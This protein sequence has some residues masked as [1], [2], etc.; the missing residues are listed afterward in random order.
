MGLIAW[1]GVMTVSG[2]LTMP[3]ASAANKSPIQ[4]GLVTSLTSSSLTPYPQ[5]WTAMQAAAAYINSSGGING[6][7]L[8]VTKCDDQDEANP[9]QACA[10]AAVHSKDVAVVGGTE[11]FPAFFSTLASAKLLFTGGLGLIPQELTS[12]TV[13]DTTSTAAGWYYGMGALAVKLGLKK[14]A[15][16][17]C[18][19]PACEGTAQ[20]SAQALKIAGDKIAPSFST[21]QL[22]QALTPAF[23]QQIM[24][25]KPEAVLVAAPGPYPQ[26]LLTLLKQAGYRGKFINNI[27]SFD[28]DAIKAVGSAANGTYVVSQLV[29]VTDSNNA[30][31]RLFDKWM[32]KIDPSAQKDELSELEFTA[33]LQF[34]QIAKR[35]PSV[36]RASVLKAYQTLKTPVKIGT[37]PSY[38]V[39]GRT[40]PLGSTAPALR[41]GEVIYSE[42]KNGKYVPISGFVDPFTK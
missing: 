12:P 30:A 38:A 36:T 21:F 6:H 9:A 37:A 14:V 34:A 33:V 17:Q 22:G 11:V 42:V 4:I 41:T 8:V 18:S 20:E 29:P 13:Y 19:I 31:I 7:R 23:A 32:N 10:T 40:S 39:V 16:V 3:L 24:Q 2:V 27:G 15:I 5:D 26:Q 35:L 28:P 1:A 25:G